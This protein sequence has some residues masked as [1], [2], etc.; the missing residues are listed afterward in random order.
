MGKDNKPKVQID[1]ELFLKIAMYF[2]LDDARTPE[3][4]QQIKDGIFHKYKALLEHDM[5]SQYKD[6]LSPEAVRERARQQYLD[7]K[8]VPDSFRW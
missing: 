1:K 7:S 3:L 4:H 5:Y 2:L 6:K 8:G